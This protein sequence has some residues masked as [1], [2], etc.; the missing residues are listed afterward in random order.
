MKML[1]GLL[2]LALSFASIASSGETKTFTYD[3]AQNSVELLLRGEKTHTEYRYE[4]RTTVCYRTEIVGYRTVCTGSGP[5]YPGP[6]PGPRP[7]PGRTCY[8]QPV[9]RQVGY[10]CS[11][12]V[13]IPYEVK[14]FDVDARVIIDVTNLTGVSTPG[15]KFVVTLHGDNLSIQTVGSKKFFLMLAK[16]SNRATM[17]GSVKFIDGL[18]AV[19]LIEAAPVLKALTMTN[20]SIENSVLSFGLGPVSSRANIG[21]A[22]TVLKKRIGSDTVLFDRE[23]DSSEVVINASTAGASAD[24]NVTNLG[25]ALNDGKYGL[26]AKAFFKANGTL[27]NKSQFGD[28][29]ETSRTL[30]YTIR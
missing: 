13:Q 3:G 16:E 19:E 24:V 9:Y 30:L 23:L 7:T 11:Q 1:V 25:V 26:T 6:R 12:T 17:N 2:S 5:G 14:D 18:Y 8:Q 29:I 15:E 20:I 21:F 10:P 28:S 27:M 4:T 22:L